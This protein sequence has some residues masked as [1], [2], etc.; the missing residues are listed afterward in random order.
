[1][2][3]RI[4]VLA[5]DPVLLTILGMCLGT[6]GHSVETSQSGEYGLRRLQAEPYDLLVLDVRLLDMSG[7]G[8]VESL[9][10]DYSDIPKRPEVLFVP[11]KEDERAAAFLGPDHVLIRPFSQHELAKKV[12]GLLGNDGWSSMGVSG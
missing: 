7:V 2:G 3:A 11:A 1:M 9:R 10:G 12:A 4:L 5:D 8:L 6:H